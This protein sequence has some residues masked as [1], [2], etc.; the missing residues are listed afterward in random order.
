[1]QAPHLLQSP[2]E[3][4]RKLKEVF[5]PPGHMLCRFD[6][7]TFYMSGDPLHLAQA[8]SDVFPPGASS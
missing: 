2:E 6:V 7:K 1:M 8:A 4:V 3:V 5:F